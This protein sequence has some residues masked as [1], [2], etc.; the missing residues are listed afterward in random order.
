MTNPLYQRD[1]IAADQYTKDDIEYVLSLTQKMKDVSDDS[2]GIDLLRHK[3]LAALFFEPSSRT[4]SSFIAAMQRLGG[5]CIPMHGMQ[6]TSM[7]KGESFQ[8]TIQTFASYADVIVIRHSQT[9]FAQH[10]ADI[11]SCPV[12]NAGDGIGEHPTQCLQDLFTIRQNAGRIDNLKIVFVGDLRH[13]RPVNSLVKALV[14]FTNVELYFVS[15]SEVSIQDSVKAY[16]QRHEMKFSEHSTLDEVLTDADVLYVTRVK[17][18]YMSQELYAQVQGKYV[19]DKKIIGQMKKQSIIMHPFPRFGE[20]TVDVDEDTR[21]VYI[22]EQM[23]NGM[24][25]RMAILSSM[26]LQEVK[27]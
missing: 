9:G 7:E 22:R 13:Y 10:A 14:H 5:G 21:A 20:I 2:G 6:H 15:A 3:V 16:L 17:K 4:F 1:I 12:V 23:K 24:Y 8:D 18:E 19:I 26:L 11:A 27:I 25:T